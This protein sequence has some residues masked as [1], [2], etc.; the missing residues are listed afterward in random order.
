M[1]HGA[2]VAE[3]GLQQLQRLPLCRLTRQ[4]LP[5]QAL[6]R[7][8]AE[9]VRVNNLVAVAAQDELARLLQQRQHQRQLHRGEVLHLV[10]DDEVV[11][12]PGWCSNLGTPG[13]SDE[14]AV[15]K[16]GL[17]Q[18]AEVP[19]EQAMRQLALRGAEQALASAQRQIVGQRQ[20][21]T[22]LGANDAAELLEQCLGVEF[23]RSSS[24]LPQRLPVAAHQP[25]KAGSVTS[26]PLGTRRVSSSSR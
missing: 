1:R 17:L 2:G 7:S 11:N 12:G 23:G 10:D 6:Q 24:Q 15:V 26:R 3:V 18:P 14:V 19:L 21:P 5:E 13:L 22:R 16:L 4:A 25:V 20:R 9:E 8:P